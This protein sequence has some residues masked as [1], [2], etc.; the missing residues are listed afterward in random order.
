[1]KTSEGLPEKGRLVIFKYEGN[2]VNFGF[3][4][5]KPEVEMFNMFADRSEGYMG[6][7]VYASDVT[8]WYYVKSLFEGDST[9][10]E[11]RPSIGHILLSKCA[12]DIF[13][14]M[15]PSVNLSEGDVE[16]R[17][18]KSYEYASKILNYCPE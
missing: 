14:A 2:G 4:Y 16:Q 8:E 1:M 18:E 5:Y 15:V 3:G 17:I 13:N 7:Y 12:T 6:R 10:S 9:P 11:A